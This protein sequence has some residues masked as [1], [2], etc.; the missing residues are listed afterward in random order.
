MAP[1]KKFDTWSMPDA[2]PYRIYH[3]DTLILIGVSTSPL[4]YKVIRPTT[5]LDIII[6][7]I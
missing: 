2:L 3:Q 1:F 4:P 5:L 6:L 7:I